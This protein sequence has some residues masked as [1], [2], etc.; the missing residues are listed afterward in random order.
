VTGLLPLASGQA[1]VIIC[2][3]SK[4]NVREVLMSIFGSEES[5]MVYRFFCNFSQ[6]WDN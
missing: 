1:C 5:V 6:R 2:K 3:V 4:S